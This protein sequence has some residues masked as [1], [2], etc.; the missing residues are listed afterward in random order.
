VVRFGGGVEWTPGSCPAARV[1]VLLELVGPLGEL[2]GKGARRGDERRPPHHR[3]G[4]AG[5]GL[6]TRASGKVAHRNSRLSRSTQGVWII[7]AGAGTL[8]P[9]ICAACT[10]R[11]SSLGARPEGTTPPTHSTSTVAGS[12]RYGRKGRAAPLIC[13]RPWGRPS[14]SRSPA[15]LARG[16][17]AA[18]PPPPPSRPLSPPTA[19]SE[20]A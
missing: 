7:G 11:P 6:P 18:P 17:G 16:Q 14:T 5:R 13:I 10:P 1:H 15:G 19:G 9:M 3:A 2:R 20:S 12:R 4:D 8:C